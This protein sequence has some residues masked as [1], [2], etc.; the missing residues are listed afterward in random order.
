MGITK[1]NGD[2][3]NLSYV[4]FDADFSYPLQW[5]WESTPARWAYQRWIWRAA[6]AQEGKPCRN[7]YQEEL[8][9]NLEKADPILRNKYKDRCE[10]VHC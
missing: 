1:Y 2:M 4:D 3:D 10:K 5:I 6:L 7:T 8:K 9:S